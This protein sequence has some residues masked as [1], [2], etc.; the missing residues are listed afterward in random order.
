MTGALIGFSLLLILVILFMLYRIQVLVSVMKGSYRKPAGTSNK[1]NAVLFLLFWIA[2]TIG[3]IWFS[4]S[5]KDQ[6]LPESAS[7]HGLETDHLFLLTT[8]IISIVFILTNFFLFFFA[9][10]YQYKEQNKAYFYAHNNKLELVWTIIPAVVMATLIIMGLKIWNNVFMYDQSKEIV[11]IE[12][13]G[14]QFDWTVRY[15]GKD[16]KLGNYDYRLIDA[17]NAMGID[18]KD[19]AAYDDFITGNKI[20]IPKGKTIRFIIRARDVLHSVHAPHFRLKMD[21]VPG[22]KTYF[23]FEANKTTEEMR[24]ELK[25]NPEWQKLDETGKPRWAGFNYEVACAEICGRGHNAMKAF[26]Y[27]LEPDEYEEWYASQTSWLATKDKEYLAS[28]EGFD[29]FLYNELLPEKNKPEEE[30]KEA[31]KP[32]ST[33]PEAVEEEEVVEETSEEA[34]NIVVGAE[35]IDEVN[36]EELTPDTLK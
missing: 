28:K 35:S 32:E 17:D 10:K 24:R 4:F 16:G 29:W 2:G 18:L 3:F 11:D 31:P 36:F 8:V 19:K 21:A 6:Y 25:E 27:V 26:I 5:S 15:P 13:M 30:E 33:T 12:I 1:V 7:V 14:K 9:Y 20:Y 23:V 34:S 22:M